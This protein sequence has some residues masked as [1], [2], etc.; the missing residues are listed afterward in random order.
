MSKRKTTFKATIK[1][2]ERAQEWLR[3]HHLKKAAG[4]LSGLINKTKREAH[5]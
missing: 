4:V 3:G 1:A 2:L 5:E